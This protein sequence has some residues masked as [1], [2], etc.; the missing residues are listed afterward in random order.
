MLAVGLAL[1]VAIALQERFR[2]G[3]LSAWVH[4]RLAV[5]SMPVWLAA[6]P[7]PGL[8]APGDRPSDG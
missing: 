5:L 7:E 4:L 3:A 2:P 8:P 6:R 1:I